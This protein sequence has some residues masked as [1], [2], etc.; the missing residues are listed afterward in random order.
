MGNGANLSQVVS[1]VHEGCYYEF[2]FFARGESANVGV[3][4][5]LTFL[6]GN[7]E[8]S[9]GEIVV[10]QQ[11]LP[12]ADRVFSYYR[13]ITS[14]APEDADAL[15]IT[16]EVTAQGKQMVDIDNVSFVSL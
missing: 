12:T 3:N 6:T 15:R 1:P 16:F 13:V 8:F 5:K 14:K 2:S 10:Q 4:A 7:G 11:C 9:A